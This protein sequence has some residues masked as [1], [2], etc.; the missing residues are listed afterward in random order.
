MKTS[1][2]IFTAFCLSFFAQAQTQ[3][4]ATATIHVKGNCEECKKRI[5][6]AADI[7]GVKFSEWDEAQ[8]LITVTYRP[9]KV[10]VEQIEKAIAKSGH[11]AGNQKSGTKEYGKLP[12][13]CRY[14][15][16]ACDD[17]QK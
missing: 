8:Q 3:P 13:C 4:V 6:N 7:P 17:K 2:V 11:D 12:K 14:R 10:N 16:A 15:D 5:E 1:L 9:D